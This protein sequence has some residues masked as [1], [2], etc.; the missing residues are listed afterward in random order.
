MAH[1]L[2]FALALLGAGAPSEALIDASDPSVFEQ[3]LRDMGYAPTKFD[4]TGETAMTR[5]QLGQGHTLSIILGGC[6]NGKGCLYVTL[7]G[8]FY[9]VTKPPADWV[10]RMN[11][12]YDLIKVWVND[13]GQLTYSAGGVMTG[14]SRSTLR[15]WIDLVHQSSRHLGGRALDD[16]L[17]TPE[18]PPLKR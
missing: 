3:Q 14:A 11:V 17:S 1:P 16:K 2:L 7:V 15:N 5:I 8:A 18:K 10:A 4:V 9:N 12:D 6:A 13:M